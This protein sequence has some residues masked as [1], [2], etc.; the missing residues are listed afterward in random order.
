[1]MV[2]EIA[3]SDADVVL[4]QL[5]VSLGG[6]CVGAALV[7]AGW[8]LR[9]RRP[10]QVA[11]AGLLVAFAIVGVLT[12]DH[13]YRH[14]VADDAPA[15]QLWGGLIGFTVGAVSII[16]SLIQVRRGEDPR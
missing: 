13:I 2:A 5:I 9:R 16:A 4:R 12:T 8:N 6:L 15:W 1:M 11:T 14:L 3:V 7:F 10:R